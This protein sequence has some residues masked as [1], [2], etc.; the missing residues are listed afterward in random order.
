LTRGG[1]FG[2]LVP[3]HNHGD[4]KAALQLLAL[5]AQVGQ[6]LA[7]AGKFL[8]LGARVQG[9]EDGVGL[10]VEGLARHATPSCVPG[11]SALG[12]VEDNGGAGQPLRG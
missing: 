8:L 9:V 11:N 2:L 12:T 1:K 3:V 10:A 6:L 4:G 5:G 7:K